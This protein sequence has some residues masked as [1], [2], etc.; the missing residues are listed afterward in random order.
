[1]E[2]VAYISGLV[3]GFILGAIGVGLVMIK[4]LALIGEESAR[5]LKGGE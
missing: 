1:V 3:V 5:A 2:L 4:V